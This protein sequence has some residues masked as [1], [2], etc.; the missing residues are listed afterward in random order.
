[1]LTKSLGHKEPANLNHERG[2]GKPRDK[3]TTTKKP[4]S[5]A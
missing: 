5:S 4:P 1:M 3:T 2:T